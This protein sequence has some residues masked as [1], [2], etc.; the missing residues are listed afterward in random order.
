MKLKVRRTLYTQ[1]SSRQVY[2]R[3]PNQTVL[4]T[5]QK[6]SVRMKRMA[7]RKNCSADG[8]LGAPLGSEEIVGRWWFSVGRCRGLVRMP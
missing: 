4:E 8:I 2:R 3:I 6:K 5:K 1:A 7:G